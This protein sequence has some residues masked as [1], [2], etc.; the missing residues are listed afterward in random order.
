MGRQPALVLRVAVAALALTVS[1]HWAMTDL[2]TLTGNATDESSAVAI[3]SGGLVVGESDSGYLD[4]RAVVWRSGKWRPLPG[5]GSAT[6]VNAVN[7]RGLI[8]GSADTRSHRGVPVA[9]RDGKLVRL[10]VPRGIVWAEA[11]AVSPGG[12]IAGRGFGAHREH[13]FLWTGGRVRDLGAA[14]SPQ[15]EPSPVV[16]GITDAPMIVWNSASDNLT[17][18]GRQIDSHVFV[19]QNGRARALFPLS[20][21]S[22]A[23]LVSPRGDVVGWHMVGKARRAF[24]WRGGPP[25]D[26]PG[27]DAVANGIN[28]SGDIVGAAG[29]DA[30]L[31]HDGSLRDLGTLGGS[32]S[33]ASAINDRGEVVGSS[34][35]AS[36]DTHGFV[37]EDGRMTDLGVLSDTADARRSEADAINAQGTIIG[38]SRTRAGFDVAVLWTP[39]P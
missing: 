29:G 18:Q 9:W 28:A 13:A 32:G 7:D 6:R 10:P 19:W 4:T 37:W 12:L 2:G 5:I 26:L 16:V 22:E 1:P 21:D 39:R 30:A 15:P 34:D 3:T 14:I 35:T 11:M 38:T 8:V 33:S 31:W 20:A 23:E 25:T 24:L 17:G 36:G 27:V